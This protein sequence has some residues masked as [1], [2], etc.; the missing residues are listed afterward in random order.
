MPI[1][2]RAI[3]EVKKSV[4]LLFAGQGAQEVGMGLKLVEEYPEANS[5]VG[6]GP[7]VCRR[8]LEKP[9]K[10]GKT[11]F[12]SLLFF[13]SCGYFGREPSGFLPQPS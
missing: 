10:H 2:D 4:V 1:N 12:R 5:C 9:W 8:P 11:H 6:Y 13:Q 7:A 3:T